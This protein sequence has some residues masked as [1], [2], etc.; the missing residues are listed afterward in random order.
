MTPDD[1]RSTQQN[2]TDNTNTILSHTTTGLSSDSLLMTC[3]V[4]VGSPNGS[5]VKARALLDS[6]SSA[7]FVSERL[8]QSLCL[9][10]SPLSATISGVAGLTHTSPVQSLATC[11]V[12][13][14][15]S[16]SEKFDVTAVVVPRVTCIIPQRPI[17]LKPEWK[18]LTGIKKADQH[19]GTP[20]KIDLLLG[21]DI[22]VAALRSGRKI[23][24]PQAPVAIE[25]VFGWVLAGRT[26]V[27]NSHVS[28]TSCH[29]SLLTGDNLLCQFW[30]TEECPSSD[31]VYSAEERQA[32][33]HFK[34]NHFRVEGGRFCVSLPKRPTPQMIGESRSQGVRRF[35]SLE[36]TL[37][38]KGQFREFSTAVQEYFD[39][40]HAELVPKSELN[41][42][43][44]SVFYLPMHAVYKESSTTT[45]LRVVFDASAKSASGV[46]LN[47]TLIVGPTVHSPLVDVLLRFRL[48]RVAIVADISR[49]YRAVELTPSDRDF[50]RF[51]WRNSPDE[52]LRDF[53]M[54]RLTFGVSASS[55][56][57]NMCVKQNAIALS[58]LFPLASTAVESSF[59]VDDCLTDAD[60]IPDA[61]QLREELRD[62]LQKGGFLLRKWNSSD[63]AVLQD[64]PTDLKDVSALHSIPCP[65]TYTKTLGVEWNT[66]LDHFRLTVSSP[67]RPD[68][69]TKRALISDV[70]RTFD[71]LGWFS[72][73]TIKLK[74]L[75]QHLWELKLEWDAIVPSFV[76]T[77]WLKWRMELP[78]LANCHIARCYFPREAHII[79]SW[80]LHGFSDASE[81]AFAGVVYLRM[82]DT[83]GNVHVSLVTSKTKVA[84]IKRLSIPRLELCGAQLLARLLYHIQQVLSV[85]SDD[86][87]AWS[88]STIVLNWLDGNPKRFKTYVGNRISSITELIAPRHWNHVDGKENPADCASRG[89]FPSELVDHTLWW[90]GPEWLRLQPSEWPKQSY[91]QPV[92]SCE[93]RVSLH[94]SLIER[95]PVM[96][97][98]RFSSFYTLKRVTAWIMRFVGNCRTSS[99]KLFS[100]CLTV[101]E[102]SR[103]EEYWIKFAQADHFAEDIENLKHVSKSSCL[104]PVHPFLDSE[105]VL[106]V[107]GREHYSQRAFIQQHP[108]ILHGSHHVTKLIIRSEHL[109][110]LHAGPT[111]LF[112][113]LSRRFHIVCGR[114]T[115]RTITRSCVTCRRL[116][117]PPQSQLVGRLPIERV[118]P[119]HVFDRVG[120]DYAGPIQIKSGAIRR[121]T[122][123]KAYVC[124]FVSLS[125]QA[126]H[127]ELVSSLS[128]EAFIACLRR[129]I[130]RRGKPVLI[131]SDH[132]SNFVGASRELKEMIN[133]L[134]DQATQ[135][136]ISEFCS[137]QGIQWKFIPERAPHFG[138][139]WEAAVKSMKTHLRRIVGTV[140]LRF[141]E[142]YTVLTQ[143]EAC[144]NSR[145]LASLPNDDDG[146]EVL[147]P[148]HFLV[149]KPLEA[150]PDPS[151]SY[152]SMSTLSRWHLCQVLVRNF[153]RRWSDEYLQSLRRYY[154][155]HETCRNL[156]V[157]D[158]VVLREDNTPPTRWP[159]ARVME[160][161]PGVDGLVRA[162][163][164]KTSSG[165]YTRPIVKMAVLVSDNNI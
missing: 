118:T 152:H 57:A 101:I 109:R 86:L 134:E 143:I 117:A 89:M 92:P 151:E 80:Q 55:F 83:G 18:H 105:D 19:F 70:A 42:P 62:L 160:T 64:L 90:N 25:T 76:K 63:P 73:A 85:K 8:A 155:N 54:T 51:V 22:F 132:G 147:T 13:S 102:L 27:V 11:T 108:A 21:V 41:N 78:L 71:V 153:W 37:Y 97:P 52:T 3:Q 34:E 138:G 141:E 48:H 1:S 77:Q 45:K 20:G 15:L 44:Q 50:H 111:L 40:N 158:V 60:S 39:M 119:G 120:I 28:I 29:I 32:V 31:Q 121:P 125:V 98:N 123:T 58:H 126:V 72:P 122:I 106:R 6:A 26:D 49:M 59:Y 24:P 5:V 75:F 84:P 17:L 82:V 30:E 136:C 66:N 145:P 113:S 103:A 38:S 87:Y 95:K 107:G 161:Y 35:L 88:D 142:L 149:G 129:F 74:I 61:I 135:K 7:S 157:G 127:L 163:K 116:S 164:V 110:L 2:S 114:K 91:H 4:V 36:R 165:V 56:L 53:R 159:L 133:F 140:N 146:V 81:A 79:I 69:L 14:T 148:G 68:N 115:I 94:S 16:S 12:S 47:D 99:D 46:S 65:D 144:L 96:S 128:T 156:Q 23:G 43:P 150:L 154:K 131:W 104:I 100:T 137:K 10:R 33:Q 9:P 162:V 130:S 93:D 67:P 124:V 112:G 139:L